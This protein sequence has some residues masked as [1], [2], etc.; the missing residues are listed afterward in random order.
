[1][2]SRNNEND[3]SKS[4]DKNILP[5]AYFFDVKERKKIINNI[6]DGYFSNFHNP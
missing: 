4:N 1:M 3:K 2:Y 6:I 5:I